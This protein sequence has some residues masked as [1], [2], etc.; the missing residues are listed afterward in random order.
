MDDYNTVVILSF[1][2]ETQHT[3][4]IYRQCLILHDKILTRTSGQ[5]IFLFFS[6]T[7]P[8]SQ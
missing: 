8:P 3:N 5:H 4:C 7:D 1:V 6:F 2:T